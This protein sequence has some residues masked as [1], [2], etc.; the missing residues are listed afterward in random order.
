MAKKTGYYDT[1]MELMQ[2]LDLDE[3][4]RLQTEVENRIDELTSGIEDIKE[5]E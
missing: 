3:L 2:E 4:N 5:D 1:I